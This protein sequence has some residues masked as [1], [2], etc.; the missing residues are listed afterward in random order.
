MLPHVSL[1]IAPIDA[2]KTLINKSQLT[3]NKKGG[4]GAIREFAERFLKL[5][6]KWEEYC[7]FGWKDNN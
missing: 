2:E 6:S 1:L 3:L 5:N 7:E 4:N